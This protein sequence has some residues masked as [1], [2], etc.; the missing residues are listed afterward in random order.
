MARFGIGN[1]WLRARAGR[2]TSGSGGEERL[3]DEHSPIDSAIDSATLLS[4]I[5]RGWRSRDSRYSCRLLTLIGREVVRNVVLQP[6]PRPMNEGAWSKEL[7][8]WDVALYVRV[9]TTPPNRYFA[10][11]VPPVP[12]SGPPF[13][14]KGG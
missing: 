5:H 10:R 13:T 7:G 14:G 1:L 4:G 9:A 11:F 2:V 8:R 12:R 6:R 3:P